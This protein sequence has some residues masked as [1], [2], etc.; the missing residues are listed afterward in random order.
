MTFKQ[1]GTFLKKLKL[2]LVGKGIKHSKS[3]QMYEELL[4]QSVDYTLLDYDNEESIPPLNDLLNEFEGISI[5]APYKHV[6][7]PQCEVD[8]FFTEMNAINCTGRFDSKLKGTNTDYLAL[9]NLTQNYIKNFEKI[10]LLGDGAMARITVA[11]FEK[12]NVEFE[13]FSRKKN[14]NFAQKNYVQMGEGKKSY[15][16]INS[17]GRQF[18]FDQPILSNTVFYDYNY[19]HEYHTDFFKNTEGEYVDGL[20]LLKSQARYA[21]KFWGIIS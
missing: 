21:L 11:L 7:I 6:F 2:A 14:D 3:Q 9:E 1:R 16:I 19:A 17:C 13:Q 15:I 18:Q 12:Y 4:N 8:P 20:D 10:V 5:T